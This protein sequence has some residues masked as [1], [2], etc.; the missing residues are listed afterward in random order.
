MCHYMVG[1]VV[2]SGKTL[3]QKIKSGYILKELKKFKSNVYSD[4][5]YISSL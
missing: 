2:N 4:K 3:L 1:W 5:I